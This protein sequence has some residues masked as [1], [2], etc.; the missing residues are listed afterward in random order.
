[1]IAPATALA[2]LMPTSRSDQPNG[3]GTLEPRVPHTTDVGNARAFA[4]HHADSLLYV[5]DL[6]EWRTWDRRRWARDDREQHVALAKQTARSLYVSATLEPDATL[7]SDAAKWAIRSESSERLTAMLRLARSEPGIAAHSSEF[8]AKPD[9]LN[10]ANGTLDLSTGRLRWPNPA[11]RLTKV[12]PAE[13]HPTATSP[14]WDRV[15]DRAMPDEGGRRDLQKA[16][17]YT[18][19]G[20]KTLDV[21]FL[22]YGP[23][24]TAK[25]TVQGAIAKTLGEY[26]VTA[27]LDAL[28]ERDR[29][30]APRPDLVRLRGARMV[31]VYETARTLRLDAALVKSLAGS[32]PITARD[33]FRAPVEFLPEFVLWMATNHRPQMPHDDDALWERLREIPFRMQIPEDER[34]PRVREKLGDPAESGAAILAWAFRGLEMVRTEGLAPASLVRAATAANRAAQDPFAEFFENACVFEKTAVTSAAM[35]RETYERSC[36]ENGDRPES[37]SAFAD[38]LRA[39]GCEPGRRHSGRFWRGVGLLDDC[40]ESDA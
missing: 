34:D 23:T 13:F 36:R 14:L 16:A 24:R 30:A 37:G 15:L 4:R 19:L 12:S 31:S 29:A 40:E 10:T 27:E 9:L 6:G 32:D 39:R 25:G 7:R 1:M 33:L 22:I 20:R 2:R 35:L 38:A 11:D 8:D 18:L 26:A 5:T 17:G 3:H 21:A 28:A